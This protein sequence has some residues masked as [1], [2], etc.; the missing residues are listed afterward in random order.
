M[1]TEKELQKIKEQYVP[2]DFEAY[3]ID[4]KN[5]KVLSKRSEEESLA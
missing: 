4:D 5:S 2:I 3:T 1:A